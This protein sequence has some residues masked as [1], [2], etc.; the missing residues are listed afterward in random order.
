MRYSVHLPNSGPL[1]SPEAIEIVAT[2][3]ELLGFDAVVTN[4]HVIWGSEDHYHNY[5]GSKEL[6]DER[7]WPPDFYEAMTLLSY[8]AARTSRIKLIP[9]AIC[10]GWRPV[11]LLARESLTLQRLSHGRFVLN[12]CIGDSERDFE[13]T[14]T[15]WEERGRITSEHL[16]ALRTIIDAT[17]P[18][19]F[20]G[21]HVK[22]TD[23]VWEPHPPLPLWY[24]GISEIAVKR[25]A[26]YAD[27]WYGGS[28][29][30]FREKLPLLREEAE[31]VGRGDVT[32]ELASNEYACVAK[33]Q[34]AAETLSRATL[35]AHRTGY[36]KKF[37]YA[38]KDA[39]APPPSRLVGTP[40]IV[41]EGVRD[42]ADS[43]VTLLNLCFIAHSLGSMLEQM[44]SFM[45]E[46]A[47]CV[48]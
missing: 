32:F 12:V 17:G 3:A 33:S 30:T 44:E 41:A 37:M 34:E 9:G 27:G 28:P 20:E 7:G 13:A 39:V 36:W 18:V 10:V 25:A 45:R 26:R 11:A 46:V 23:A 15:S 48:R 35:D 19:S 40:E 2:T 38:K 5:A 14:R 43:G 31:K 21:K 8:I 4:D 1:G 29:E 16:R 42:Y 6:D 24:G 47:P 22:F